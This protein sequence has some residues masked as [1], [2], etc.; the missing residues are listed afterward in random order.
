VLVGPWRDTRE[1]AVA[2]AIRSNQARIGESGDDTLWL[3]PGSIEASD[4]EKEPGPHV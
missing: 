4:D 1:Q 3:V 2:D